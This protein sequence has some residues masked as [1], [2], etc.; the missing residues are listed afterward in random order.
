MTDTHLLCYLRA[1]TQLEQAAC[2]GGGRLE[3][4]EFEE[5]VESRA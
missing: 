3:V 2:E 4:V 5:E 1:W